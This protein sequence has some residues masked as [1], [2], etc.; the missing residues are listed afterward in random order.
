MKLTCCLAVLFGLIPAFLCG[1]ETNYIGMKHSKPHEFA[2][3]VE[4]SGVHLNFEVQDQFALE[5]KVQVKASTFVVGPII[6]YSFCKS[7]ALY[8]MVDVQTGFNESGVS[9]YQN[10]TLIESSGLLIASGAIDLGYTLGSGKMLWSPFLG[11]NGFCLGATYYAQLS[12]GGEAGVKW[13]YSLG[14]NCG[15]GVN[16]KL[17]FMPGFRQMFNANGVDIW[18]QKRSLGGEVSVPIYIGLKDSG[19]WCFD[20][21]PFYTRVRFAQAEDWFGLRVYLG[22][23]F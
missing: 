14:E 22:I 21:E 2:F 4:V 6:K 18:Q 10:N 7:G 13:G 17:L 20:L 12:F 23:S 3:G 16:A 5:K 11:I 19:G 1:D 9:F 8:A 15:V